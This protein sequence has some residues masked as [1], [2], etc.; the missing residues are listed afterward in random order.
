[1]VIVK[2]PQWEPDEMCIVNTRKEARELKKD[3]DKSVSEYE[4][5]IVRCEFKLSK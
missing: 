4:H 2:D 1:M 3:C 5:M